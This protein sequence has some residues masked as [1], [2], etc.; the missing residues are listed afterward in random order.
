MIATVLSAVAIFAGGHPAPAPVHASAMPN[1]WRLWIRIGRCEQ[2]G[3]GAWGIRWTHPGPS[4]Q[5]GLGFYH[6]TWDGWKP[7]GYPGD[8]GQ[9]SWR[10]QMI[11]ANRVARSVGF[12]AWGCYARVR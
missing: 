8:A 10:Q 3:R 7:R 2:P 12:S 4:Y 1:N 11:V 6:R 9:A 5:G